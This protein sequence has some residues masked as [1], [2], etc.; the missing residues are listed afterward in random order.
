[1]HCHLQER[2]RQLDVVGAVR[3]SLPFTAVEPSTTDAW[4]HCNPCLGLPPMQ[5]DAPAW[6][7]GSQALVGIACML[8][9]FALS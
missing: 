5:I 8:I 9:L 2:D 4:I 3:A 1:M 7:F 6:F